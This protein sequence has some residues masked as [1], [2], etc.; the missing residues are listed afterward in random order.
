[1]E[2]SWFRDGINIADDTAYLLERVMDVK[3]PE[4][5]TRILDDAVSP[6]TSRKQL[7][8]DRV[9]GVYDSFKDYDN[10]AKRWSRDKEGFGVAW[11][12]HMTPQW[13]E[14]V[15]SEIETNPHRS[16]YVWIEH[17]REMAAV[18]ATW[19]E[20]EFKDSGERDGL[21]L[22]A[23]MMVDSVLR[24][25]DQLEGLIAGYEHELRMIQIEEGGSPE[26]QALAT[27]PPPPPLDQAK[28]ITA[29][30]M[31]TPPGVAAR[32]LTEAPNNLNARAVNDEN[33]LFMYHTTLDQV[34]NMMVD[35][36]ANFQSQASQKSTFRL[37]NVYNVS[38]YR[39]TLKDVEGYAMSLFEG[40]IVD[41]T[42]L[43]STS[44]DLVVDDRVLNKMDFCFEMLGWCDF[45]KSA[46]NDPKNPLTGRYDVKAFIPSLN[47][48]NPDTGGRLLE[49]TALPAYRPISIDIDTVHPPNEWF[50]TWKALLGLLQPEPG[51]VDPVVFVYM[52]QTGALTELIRR[53]AW[54]YK[55]GT[56]STKP[57]TPPGSKTASITPTQFDAFCIQEFDSANEF[58]Q[59]HSRGAV[60]KVEWSEWTKVC[61]QVKS[62]LPTRRL[63]R[64]EALAQRFKDLMPNL[65]RPEEVAKVAQDISDKFDQT[66][67][68]QD[69]YP[70]LKE[71]VNQEFSTESD[72]QKAKAR[73]SLFKT[74]QEWLKELTKFNVDVALM[75]YVAK[76]M[77]VRTYKAVS[78]AAWLTRQ[79]LTCVAWAVL[80]PRGVAVPLAVRWL[81]FNLKMSLFLTGEVVKV[82]FNI[83][84]WVAPNPLVDSLYETRR[85]MR[86]VLS[87]QIFKSSG[88][89]D[90]K[91]TPS[92]LYVLRLTLC[93]ALS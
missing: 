72:E 6:P 25:L 83:L 42:R 87:D 29:R 30:L 81:K 39:H 63:E 77:I 40:F 37:S 23:R 67:K 27:P 44:S 48:T 22:H 55:K 79:C 35:V 4:S 85:F 61:E 47:L 36:L 60:D 71:F 2:R 88:Y 73:D 89:D 26:D 59:Q 86:H 11:R 76:V 28:A 90:R 31:L 82:G 18:T 13:N 5:N 32:K 74:V 51:S 12:Q 3:E 43:L 53:A 41:V 19:A 49:Q 78:W 45:W 66:G 7:L 65:P 58:I 57:H 93:T 54:E 50:V 33:L 56:L 9:V 38:P 91:D 16:F 10:M 68:P 92:Q 84:D 52:D 64:V 62:T 69:A 46:R 75:L 15:Q 70:R 1:M 80:H 24:E 20:R 14:Q 21:V 8:V 34:R 17:T